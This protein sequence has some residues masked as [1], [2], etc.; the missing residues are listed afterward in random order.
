[1]NIYELYALIF[2]III[3]VS[4]IDNVHYTPQSNKKIAKEIK[5]II[6]QH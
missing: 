3:D 1:M 2:F 4:Y 6:F 5:K